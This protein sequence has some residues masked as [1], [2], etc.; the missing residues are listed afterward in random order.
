MDVW[1]LGVLFYV[2]L[3]G[4]FPFKGGSNREMYCKIIKGNYVIPERIPI[5]PKKILMKMLQVD[6]VHRR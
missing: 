5:N 2:I 3:T 1:A 6:P 4:L